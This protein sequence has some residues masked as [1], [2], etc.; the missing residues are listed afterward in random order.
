MLHYS[1]SMRTRD[2]P[3]ISTLALGHRAYVYIRQ[4]T[5]AYVTAI[6]YYLHAYTIK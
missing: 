6:Y 1:R 4:I 3:D 5:H 2:L